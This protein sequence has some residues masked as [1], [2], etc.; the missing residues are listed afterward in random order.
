VREWLFWGDYVGYTSLK[1]PLFDMA[2]TENLCHAL[3][4]L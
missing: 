3:E 4:S 1:A 2:Q